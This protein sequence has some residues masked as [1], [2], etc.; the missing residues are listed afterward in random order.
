MAHAGFYRSER[1]QGGGGGG[2]GGE[3]GHTQQEEGPTAS[4]HTMTDITDLVLL[5]KN[6]RELFVG[7]GTESM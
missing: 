5:K 6:Q 2:V 4:G 3:A 7:T 1:T